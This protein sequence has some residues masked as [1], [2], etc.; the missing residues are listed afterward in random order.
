MKSYIVLLNILLLFGCSNKSETIEYKFNTLKNL[1]YNEFLN[2][3][4]VNRKGIYFINYKEQQLKVKNGFLGK[5]ITIEKAYTKNTIINL[6]ESD[7]DKIKSALISFKKL[8]ILSLKVDFKQNVL[9]SV[10]CS[11]Y[12]TYYLLKLSSYSTL[13]DIKK[14]Y[15]KQYIENWY[16]YKECANRN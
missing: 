12:C 9:I 11:D 13:E 6:T 1:N 10:S 2:M 4:I 14:Q 3:S 15:Y 16:L 8:H 7:I 5:T